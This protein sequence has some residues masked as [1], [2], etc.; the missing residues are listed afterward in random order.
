MSMWDTISD[1]EPNFPEMDGKGM[2]EFETVFNDEAIKD[3]VYNAMSI[4]QEWI[5]KFMDPRRDIDREVGNPE[6]LSAQ[7]YK[8]LWRR[9]PIARRAVSLVPDEVWKK[10]PQVYEKEATGTRTAWDN[11]FD[12]MCRS[13]RGVSPFKSDDSGNP[14]FEMLQ[15]AD[16]LSRIGQFGIILWGFNDKKDL[17]EPVEGLDITGK[18]VKTD[19]S[20]A[21]LKLLY[22]RPIDESL[23]QISEWETR[24]T[25]RFGQPVMYQV[26]LNDPTRRASGIGHNTTTVDVHWTRITHLAPDL[27]SNE[28]LACPTL[29]PIV[30]DVLGCKKVMGAA[31][32]GYWRGAFPGLSIE[33]HPG[34]GTE[35]GLDMDGIKR[36]MTEYMNRL[37]RYIASVG[38]SVKS[39]APQVVSPAD[40]LKAGME[41]I[42][43]CLN[44]PMRKFLGSERG[45]LSSGQDKDEFDETIQGITSNYTIP[46]VLAAAIDRL[47]Y[48]GVLPWPESD[49]Y[50]IEW[51][52]MSK[53]GA[54]DKAEVLGKRT[55]A[56]SKYQ[57]GNV[58]Q[59]M[60]PEDF[61]TREMDYTEDEA[62]TI[63][64]KATKYAEDNP[65][66]AEQEQA[67]KKGLEEEGNATK[68]EGQSGE[69]QAT[70]PSGPNA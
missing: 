2:P 28:V 65:D 69:Q 46:R 31:Y 9:D 55:D 7:D 58:H 35:V 42:C 44:V 50:R 30:N 60:A 48:V 52:D 19:R 47:I 63:T 43:V 56:M 49:E 70:N 68:Q 38:V 39:L 40:A 25:R 45:E 22:A 4:R 1:D 6:T 32:E 34:L 10:Q 67:M 62:K 27:D 12:E 15:R 24:N 18:P 29:E 23:V 13:L 53:L 51:A 41:R 33:S 11:A 59:L 17:R 3:I 16:E 64:E 21:K 66:L 8:Q 57:A 36:Q 20:Q 37:S 26:T 54:V 5:N 61:L 14:F